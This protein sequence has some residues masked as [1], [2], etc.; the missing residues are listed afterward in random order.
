MLLGGDLEPGK[1]PSNAWGGMSGLA[2]DRDM[3]SLPLNTVCL[4]LCY[5]EQ[6]DC[7]LLCIC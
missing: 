6:V 4:F 7:M 1:C 2:I 5:I 3:I